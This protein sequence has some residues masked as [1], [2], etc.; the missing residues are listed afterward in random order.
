MSAGPEGRLGHLTRHFFAALFDLGFLNEVAARSFTRLILGICALLLS[1]GVA[2]VR[3]YMIKY[4]TLAMQPSPGPYRLALLADHAFFIALPMWIIALVTTLA[5]HAVFPDETDFRVLSPLPITRRLIFSAKL[6]A[7]LAFTGL[8]VAFAEVSLIPVAALTLLSRWAPGGF[9]IRF[10]AYGLSALCAAAFA[11]LAVMSVQGL[12]VLTTSAGRALGASAAA[13]SAMLCGLMLTLPLLIRLPAEGEAMAAGA[14]WMTIAPP[15]WFAGLEAWLGGDVRPHLA[16]MAAL[17]TAGLGISGAL[18]IAVYAVL[19]R[20][21]DRLIVRPAAKPRAADR[22][23]RTPAHRLLSRRPVFLAIRAFTAITLRRSVLHQ[24]V[25]VVL[26]AIGAG[27]VANSF[28]ARDLAGGL[29]AGGAPHPDLARA[30][31]W[32]PFAL[33]YVVCRAVRMALLVPL[34]LKANWVFRMTERGSTRVDQLEAAVRVVQVLGVVAPV[35]L[36]APIQLRLLGPAAPAVLAATLLVGWCYVEALMHGWSRIPFTCSFIPGK[37][38]V[39][40]RVLTGTAA[41]VAFTAAGSWLA[42]LAGASALAG[43]PLPFVVLVLTLVL[44]SWRRRTWRDTPLEFEDVL[45]SDINPLR[46]QTE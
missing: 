9:A 11:A 3:V 30:V 23:A 40:Q 29:R 13:R 12:L 25:V 19:Y 41:F 36:L 18:V 32:A 46:I 8:F 26:S 15:A 5:G 45:P 16:W 34:D 21:F 31:V 33:M 24:G 4:G 28:I 37:G 35:A 39:P 10:G 44:R 42:G 7:L 43:A 17:A 2:Q 22:S 14:W 38:F 1:W 6:L 20:R 27:L